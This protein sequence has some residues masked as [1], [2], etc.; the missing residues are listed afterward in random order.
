MLEAGSENLGKL[1]KTDE[2]MMKV[3]SESTD[4]AN[5]VEVSAEQQEMHQKRL[6]ILKGLRQICKNKGYSEISDPEYTG[7]T[8]KTNNLTDIAIEFDTSNLG[9]LSVKIGLDGAV[10]MTV[11]PGKS[12]ISSD[13][14]SRRKELFEIREQLRSGDQRPGRVPVEPVPDLNIV[15]Q[16]SDGMPLDLDNISEKRK[17]PAE[18]PVPRSI[19]PTKSV[20]DYGSDGVIRELPKQ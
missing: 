6:K 11:Q 2:E 9:T 3:G 1:S 18:S 7:G 15:V 5:D 4:D 19:D 14:E 20:L 8:E 16:Y 17:R 10:V 12:E 13:S